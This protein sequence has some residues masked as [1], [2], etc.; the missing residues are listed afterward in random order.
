MKATGVSRC[1]DELGRIVIPKSMRS[2]LGINSG[3]PL[4]FRLEDGTLLIGKNALSDTM[5]DLIIDAISAATVAILGLLTNIKHK[6]KSTA[7][8]EE[9]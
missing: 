1:I 8:N 5:G 4:E 3:D 2:K 9:K 6:K 7:Q